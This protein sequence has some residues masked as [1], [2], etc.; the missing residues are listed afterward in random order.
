MLRLTPAVLAVLAL[1]VSSVLMAA[2]P[3]AAQPKEVKVKVVCRPN[4]AGPT[5][6]AVDPWLL[7]LTV[8]DE[9]TWKLNITQP[10]KNWIVVAPKN[11]GPWPYVEKRHEGEGEAHAAG[12][13]KYP[14]G[15]YSYNITVYCADEETV[16]DPRVRV[17]P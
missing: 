12:M 2:P 17:G 14:L 13:K 9:T 6:V 10:K 16:I 5:S 3:A 11:N 4:D 8:G 1:A 15:T 7:E